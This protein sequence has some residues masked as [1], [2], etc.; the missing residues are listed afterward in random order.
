MRLCNANVEHIFTHTQ[1]GGGQVVKYRLS[2]HLRKI[3][4]LQGMQE[5]GCESVVK[6]DQKIR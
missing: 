4:S 6:N 2:D 5:S 3:E 1:Y